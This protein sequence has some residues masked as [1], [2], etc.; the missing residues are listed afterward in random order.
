MKLSGKF[1]EGKSIPLDRKQYLIYGN[2]N[3]Q[4][5]R[6]EKGVSLDPFDRGGGSLTPRVGHRISRKHEEALKA[7]TTFETAVF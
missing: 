4:E 2:K 6:T 7:L 5:R 1:L 3:S